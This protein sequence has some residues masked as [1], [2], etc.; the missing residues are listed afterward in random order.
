M[1]PSP[2]T[3]ARGEAVEKWPLAFRRGL[4]LDNSCGAWDVTGSFESVTLRDI[5]YVF[6]R[7]MPLKRALPKIIS[8]SQLNID[9]SKPNSASKECDVNTTNLS[10]M[11]RYKR[12]RASKQ[13]FVKMFNDFKSVEQ[14]IYI[15]TR[16]Y[17]DYK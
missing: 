4:S 7:N 3:D 13:K 15:F 14:Q 8:P 17:Y 5:L 2:G 16:K 6:L 9:D 12:K 11:R 1:L 10:V